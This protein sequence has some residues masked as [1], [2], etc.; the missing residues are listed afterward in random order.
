MAETMGTDS[1][2]ADD[3]LAD[4][5][6]AIR[7]AALAEA[8]KHRRLL[9]SDRDGRLLSALMLPL[10]WPRVPAGFAVLTTTGRRSGKLR[11]KCIRAV[12]R[13]NQVFLVQIRPPELAIERPMA[14]AA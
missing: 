14:V 1:A 6:A 11:R 9:R 13:G 3:A 2:M 8:P 10:F 4:R 7:E 12:R 5:A